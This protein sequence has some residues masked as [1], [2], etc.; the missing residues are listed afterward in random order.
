MQKDS[1]SGDSCHYNIVDMSRKKARR[2]FKENAS[3]L[4]DFQVCDEYNE[5]H[6][7]E[8]SNL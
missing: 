3:S 2:F 7:L 8:L 6:V 4:S 5:S 1:D